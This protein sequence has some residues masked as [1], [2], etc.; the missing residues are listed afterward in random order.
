MR[1][2]GLLALLLATTTNIRTVAVEGFLVAPTT[3]SR[4]HSLSGWNHVKTLDYGRLYG[5]SLILHTS[6]NNDNINNAQE[7]NSL[8][9]D[10]F[11][12]LLFGDRGGT[13]PTGLPLRILSIGAVMLSSFAAYLLGTAILNRTIVDRLGVSRGGDAFGPFATLLSLIYSIVLGQIYH[14]YFERQQIIQNCL[15]E[16]AAALQLLFHAVDSRRRATPDRDEKA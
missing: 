13:N 2:C 11:F 12:R 6:N 8:N 1:A 10:Y 15:Y 3:I 16:E 14:Y 9:T 5:S 7:E 4:V